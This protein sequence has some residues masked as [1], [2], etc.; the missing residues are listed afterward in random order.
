MTGWIDEVITRLVNDCVIT[1][2]KS[3]LQ[4]GKYND[5]IYLMKLSKDDFPDIID[6][7][8]HLAK[9]K[10]YSKIFAKVPEYAND[11]FIKNGYQVEAKIPGFFNGKEDVYFLGKY[12]SGSRKLDTRIAE[13]NTILNVAGS[14]KSKKNFNVIDPALSH[15]FNYKICDRSCVFQM[16]DLYRKVFDTYP[17]PIFDPQYLLKTMDE[18]FI[19][20]SMWKNDTIVALSSCEMDVKAQNVEMTDFATLQEYQGK[21][22]AIYLLNNME[23]EMRKRKIKTAYTISRAVSYGINIIFVKMGYEYCGTL[24]NNTNIS[25]NFESMN[26]WYKLL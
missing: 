22:L 11:D 21:G 20:S 1:I 24:V 15:G 7:L 12:F 4:H 2:G 13:I 5:R 3:I 19:Y 8:D 16:A 17:F 6:Q 23:K 14:K 9:E 10:G 25:G 18:N 26:V